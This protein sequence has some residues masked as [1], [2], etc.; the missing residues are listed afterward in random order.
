MPEKHPRI[1]FVDDEPQIP[2]VYGELLKRFGYDVIP[3][4]GAAGALEIFQES[5]GSFDLIIAD[6]DMPEMNGD[7]LLAKLA[8]IRPDIPTI[9]ITGYFEAVSEENAQHLGITAFLVK[10]LK[11]QLLADTIHGLLKNVT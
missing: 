5:P 4:T 1:L 11:P 10:P 9:L 8:G 2:T 3:A 7:A 6:F